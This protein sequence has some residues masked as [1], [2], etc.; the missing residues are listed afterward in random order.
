ML[1]DIEGVYDKDPTNN[2]DAMLIEKVTDPY[3]LE[4]NISIGDKGSFGTGGIA[5]KVEAAKIVNKYGTS[6]I[7]AMGKEENIILKLSDGTAKG[8]LFLPEIQ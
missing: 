6:L 4:N 1:S 8:T 7:V 5:T 2:E 3:E